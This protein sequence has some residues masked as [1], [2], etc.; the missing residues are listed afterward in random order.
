[1]ITFDKWVAYIA[2]LRHTITDLTQDS[3]MMH[4][5]VCLSTL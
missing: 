1:M 3:D 2:G 4:S 5:I